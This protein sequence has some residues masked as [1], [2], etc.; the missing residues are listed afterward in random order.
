MNVDRTLDGRVEYTGPFALP[1]YRLTVGGYKVPYIMGK[2]NKDGTWFLS[3][4]GRFG[5]DTTEEEISKWIWFVANAMAI[6][7]GY[8]CFGPN[9]IHRNIF[10]TEMIGLSADDFESIRGSDE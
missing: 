4:D 7:A 9:S 3:L 10:R 2:K 6:A 8:S 1:E 5:I